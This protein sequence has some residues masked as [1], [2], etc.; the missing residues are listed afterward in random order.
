MKGT[1]VSLSLRAESGR[2]AG[3]GGKRMAE[4]QHY[5]GALAKPEILGRELL[6]QQDWRILAHSLLDY[7]ASLLDSGDD[8]EHAVPP[9]RD[10]SVRATEQHNQRWA[11]GVMA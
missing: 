8:L 11:K 1:L 2:G 6:A 9:C 10:F 5:E 4:E 3:Q 7:P